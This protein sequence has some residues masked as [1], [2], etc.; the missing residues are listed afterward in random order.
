VGPTKT[1]MGLI[2]RG[3]I[4]HEPGATK[5]HTKI[6]DASQAWLAIVI[7]DFIPPISEAA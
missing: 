6:S 3:F 5:Y 7:G 2:Q 4:S 1:L